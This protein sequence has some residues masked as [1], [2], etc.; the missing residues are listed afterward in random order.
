MPANDTTFKATSTELVWLGPT[1]LAAHPA[2]IRDD[3]GSTD[4]AEL[5]ASIAARGVLQPLIVVPDETGYRVV[6]GHRRCAAAVAAGVPFV[7]CLLRDDLAGAADQVITMLV[8]NTR[9]RDL[10]VSEEARG[11]AQLALAGLSAARI[12]KATGARPALVKR[13]LTVADSAVATATTARYGLSLDQALAVAEFDENPEVVRLLVV[14]ATKDPQRWDHVLARLRTD[15]DTEV[16]YDRAVAQ[17]I[18]AGVQVV[19][20]EALP[21]TARPV[22]RLTD[23]E[24]VPLDGDVHASC[25]GHVVVIDPY[26][27]GQQTMFCVE[28][29]AYGHRDRRS[30]HADPS[31]TAT[32]DTGKSAETAK[33]ERRAVIEGNRA[34]RAARE[35]RRAFLRDLLARKTA[36]KGALRY[37]VAAIVSS[38]ERV[39]DGNEELVAALLGVET[40]PT[41]GWQ[42]RRCAGPDAVSRAGDARL[43]LLLLAQVAADAETAMHDHVWRETQPSQAARWLTWLASVGYQLADIEA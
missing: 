37:A 1:A 12:A 3:L 26:D 33:A 10:N 15:R 25:P 35:V 9:R 24:G 20:E 23:E 4:L 6:A 16:A 31:P 19:D 2:N 5:T 14:T 8:E 41:G 27:P 42:P 18:D 30:R 11:Y 13:S 34:W 36:P 21:G 28:P 29:A 32:G 43:P 22:S 39:G 7:P 17:L 40:A 38:P